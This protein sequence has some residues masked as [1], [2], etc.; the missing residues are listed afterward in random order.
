MYMYTYVYIY[1]YIYIACPPS[2]SLHHGQ[3]VPGNP[4]VRNLRLALKI[5]E[6]P[7]RPCTS[8]WRP[9]PEVRDVPTEGHKESLDAQGIYCGDGAW[10]SGAVRGI[11][12]I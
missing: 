7:E 2:S 8:S 1:I 12:G 11:G 4:C 3:N 10:H 5:K 6:W 9:L